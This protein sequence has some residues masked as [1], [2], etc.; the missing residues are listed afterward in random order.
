MVMTASGSPARLLHECASRKQL[1]GVSD[2]IECSDLFFFFL[3]IR[4]V[5]ILLG[6][7]DARFPAKEAVSGVRRLLFCDLTEERREDAG[8]ASTIISGFFM[9]MCCKTAK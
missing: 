5:S 8:L 1:H 3:L 4:T 9:Q 7:G 6:C 2:E